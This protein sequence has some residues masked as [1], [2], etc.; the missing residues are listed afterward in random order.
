MPNFIARTWCA[1]LHRSIHHPTPSPAALAD[2][3]AVTVLRLNI[4][5]S[6]SRSK[7]PF[8][9]DA[10]RNRKDNGLA[11]IAVICGRALDVPGFIR[12]RD[13]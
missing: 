7:L 5:E 9:E 8:G 11:N 3:F 6:D 13:R 12:A 1:A 4:C 2:A 10:A